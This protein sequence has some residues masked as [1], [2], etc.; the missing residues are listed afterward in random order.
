MPRSSGVVFVAAHR[1]PGVGWYDIDSRLEYSCPA[2][3]LSGDCSFVS[4]FEEHLFI[5][6]SVAEF[7][8]TTTVNDHYV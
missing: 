5:Q 3:S 2:L 8:E 6:C 4:T 1:F 7:T